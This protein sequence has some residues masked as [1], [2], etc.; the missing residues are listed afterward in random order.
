MLVN[1]QSS[2]S[3]VCP[4][5]MSLPLPRCLYRP[6]EKLVFLGLPPAA[7]VRF[8][9]TVIFTAVAPSEQAA[10]ATPSDRRR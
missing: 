3:E 1:H 9:M 10:R 2:A 6:L 5:V 7:L 8:Q 4:G